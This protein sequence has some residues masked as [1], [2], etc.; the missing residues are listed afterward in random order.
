MKSTVMKIIIANWKS[1]KSA[2]EAD[3]WFADFEKQAVQLQNSSFEVVIAPAFIHIH[4]L[5]WRLK[6]TS[7]L[8]N[9]VLAVQD[10]SSFPAGSYTGA[11]STQNL[12]SLG[13]SYALVGH[14][15]R[16]RYFHETHQDVANKVD[17]ALQA[18]IKPVV[19]ID[20]QYLAAQAAALS[21]EQLSECI[22]AY[23][24][25]EAIGSGNNATA[26]DVTTVSDRIHE[27]FGAVPV[28]YGGSVTAANVAEY[29]TITDGVLVGTASL[30]A[31]A[32]VELL[33]A[34]HSKV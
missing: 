34:A 33:T 3:S 23:E 4:P 20:E 26:A 18:G 31:K 15:E 2:A 24:P 11:I 27:V 12:A 19:C 30:E 1:H 28:I 14:S 5:S 17:Q 25:L 9:T 21:K 29:L 22:V 8:K 7:S 32:F 6:N 10:L 16:R 13:I